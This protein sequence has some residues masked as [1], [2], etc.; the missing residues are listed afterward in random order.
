M[1]VSSSPR[2]T[3]AVLDL[4]SRRF[5]GLKIERLL[6]LG[7]RLQPISVRLLELG[8]GSAGAP[9]RIPTK[10]LFPLRRIITTLIYRFRRTTSEN[11]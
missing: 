11:S 10:A 7:A 6:R 2:Q 9:R 3:H 1:N 4:P 5:K 8:T